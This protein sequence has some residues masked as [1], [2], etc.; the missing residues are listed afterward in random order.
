MSKTTDK[1]T[2]LFNRLTTRYDVP[3]SPVT[4]L[5]VESNDHAIS[6]SVELA[7]GTRFRHDLDPTRGVLDLNR[8]AVALIHAAA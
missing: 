7:N 6:I 8:Q 5:G 4:D 2:R 3:D 1:A